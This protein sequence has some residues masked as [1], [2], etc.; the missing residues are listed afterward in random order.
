LIFTFEEGQT[1]TDLFAR[2]PGRVSIPTPQTVYMR[3][4]KNYFEP[5]T[6]LGILR[7]LLKRSH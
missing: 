4:E 1:S 6:L 2:A 5:K 3:L 7:K